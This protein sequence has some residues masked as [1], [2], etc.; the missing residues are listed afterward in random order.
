MAEVYRIEIPIN[1]KDNTDPGVSQAKNKLN[2]FDKASQRTQERLE[3]MNKTKYQIVLDALDRASSIV[4]KV[5]SKARSIAGKTFSFTMKV[6]DL[7]TAPLR[8]LW[9]FATSI[10]GAIL[11][12]TGAFAGIYKPMDIAADFEQ[13]QIAFETMLKS[14]EKAQQFLK[15]ASEFANKTPFE[16]PELINSSK[17]LMA[18][19]FEADKVLDM[20]KTIGDTASGLGAGSEGIDRIT[21]ALGQMQAKGR[22]QTEE[23]LQLQELGVPAN[24]ILQEELGLTGEQIANIGKESIEA[25]KVIDALLRGMEKRFGG[26]MA[27]QSRT[28]KGMISTLKDTL[29]N[30]LLRPWGQG[31]WEG[32]KPGLEKLTTWIDENQDIIAQWGEAWKKAGANIS[33]WVMARVDDL[34]N[35]IQRMVNSQEWK[36]AKNFGEKLKIAWDKIIAQPFNEWWNSTG[37]AWLAD[38]AEK[39]GEGIGTALSAG[40][41]AILG[42]DARGAVE[43]GTSIGA[44]FA[45]GFS[46]G[47]DGKKV[48]EA[49]L[50]AIK[51]VFKDA[52]TLLPGGEEASSTS[53]LSAGAIVLALQ[54]LGIFKLIGKGGKGLISL[55]G[56]GSKNGTPDTTGIPSAY[57]TDTMY[58]TASIV[59]VYGKT[60]QGPG[61]GSP[62]GGG[63]PPAGDSPLA[64]PGA[65][66]AAGKA[67]NTVQLSNGTYVVT[68]GAL[69]AGLAKTGVALG[70]GATTAGGAIAAGA[71]SVLGGALGIVGLGA[72]AVDIYQGT[73]KTGKEAKDEYFQGGTKIGMV[74][75]GA[76]IGAAVGS[77]VPVVGTGVGALVG[78]GIGGV[79]ALFT[80]DK[81]GKSL[82]DATD[83]GGWLA[84][85]AEAVG[86]FFTDTLPKGWNKFWGGVGNFFTNSIP[87]WWNGLTEKVSAFFTE[88]IPE[89]WNELWDGIG[90]F[91]TETVPYAL[92][93]AAG[94]IEVFFTEDVPR[95]FSD[96]W[97]GISTFFTST[98]PTWASN[99]WSGHIV[100][101]FTVDIPNFFGRLWSNISTF[102][103]STLPTWATD[104]WNNNIVP[105]FTQDIPNFF[106]GLWTGITTFF[107]ST[108]PTWASSVWDN[109]IVPF[110]TQTIP[111]FF[112]D[113][114]SSVTGFF[115]QTLPTL[116]SNV[117]G[118]IKS[119]F[120]DT[121]PNFF[122]GLWDKVSGSFGAG[123]SAAKGGSVAEHAWGGIITKP[124]MGIVAEDGAEGIIPLSP[125]KRQRGIDLWQRTGEILGVRTYAD[126]GIVGDEPDEIPVASATGTAGPNVTIKVEVKAE[127]TFTIESS[128]DTTDESKV[129]A[130]LKAYIREMTDD[131]GDELAERLARIFANMPVKGGAEA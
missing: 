37:K 14:A 114:W 48:G 100:P 50:N 109:N 23:L 45:E 67:L 69:A 130:I 19:G 86:N 44:S 18:F 124:H 97:G 32:I 85:T 87:T 99:V 77:V 74:G 13:T 122:S 106:G 125:S 30:S 119:F 96:L 33:K 58:A 72:G 61:G 110:F 79:A 20:L 24:Q 41:L 12:A 113:L 64:L 2:A 70:S 10:Q 116:A 83:E 6:I 112:A 42:I 7:A 108:L 103:T 80:G 51:G 127:P 16:F 43:D 39:I 73:K 118:S 123:Y 89:K 117:W 8:S 76:G 115:T 27:N 26:M 93:Y 131:I 47:F 25:A 36:D 5:S 107:T 63:S 98:L 34:R 3:Q 68:G 90:D 17:L 95:F 57:S 71:S 101:F 35:S 84:N 65:A 91:F 4:G 46:K 22:A 102:F 31:L 120:T 28:A 62:T 105:F 94:T 15:E 49:I 104:T 21:R 66:G 40:L 11:G 78:A 121:I 53:W 29:Q 75:A 1:I 9:N 111:G 88:T 129:V 38:K 82:S 60:I 56:K 128:G 92:G 81:A 52:G 126:G 54:K 59:Y 55:L